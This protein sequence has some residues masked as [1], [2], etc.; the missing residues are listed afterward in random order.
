[1][2][3]REA[4]Q[5]YIG[6]VPFLAEVC[7]AGSEIVVHDMTDP[8]HSLVAIENA[9]SGREIGNP[10]TDLA[11]EV[12]EKSAYTDADYLTN[13]SGRTKNGL[14]LSSTYFIKNEGRLIGLLC[15]NKDIDSV[16]Q[17]SIALDHLMEQFNLRIP[18]ESA[19]SE[20]LESPVESI[21]HT[22]IT[23]VI[24]QSGVSPARMS[25]DEKIAVVHRLNES[26]VMSIKGAVAEV[27]SQ[28]S[29]SVPTV[30]RY[31]NKVIME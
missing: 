28:L 24:N 21:M 2:T 29:I 25:M 13:Y 26:G 7:G 10:L 11:R 1:M 12:A 15:I 19:L 5:V 6:L 22:R 17:V 20:N 14:F 8:E 23:E 31:M 18:H 27:A 4:L 30:Y 3:D 16:H 9:I